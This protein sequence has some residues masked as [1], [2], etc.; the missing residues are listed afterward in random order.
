M[1]AKFV[2]PI[3]FISCLAGCAAQQD[4]FSKDKRPA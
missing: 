2:L 4:S 1:L 3:L